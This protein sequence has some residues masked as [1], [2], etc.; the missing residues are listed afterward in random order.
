MTARRYSVW[1]PRDATFWIAV[2]TGMMLWAAFPPLKLWPLAWVAPAGW[3]WLARR[4]RLA[5]RRPYLQLYLA[6]CVH[7]LVM[8]QWVRLPHWSAMFG[9]WVLAL[10][11]FLGL[12]N[13]RGQ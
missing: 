1:L 3:V 9:W 8:T 11:E 6:G 13:L 7:W 4:P 10:L 12:V 5:G 2:I